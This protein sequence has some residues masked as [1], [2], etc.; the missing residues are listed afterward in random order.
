MIIVNFQVYTKNLSTLKFLTVPKIFENI[1]LINNIN[2]MVF[3]NGCT[4]GSG[5][6]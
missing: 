5:G 2:N 1:G 4:C 6:T 3:F